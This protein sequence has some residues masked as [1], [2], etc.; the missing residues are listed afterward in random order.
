MTK[1]SGRVR[2]A[3]FVLAATV[4]P[5]AWV[6][7]AIPVRGVG[8]A[9]VILGLVPAYLAVRW[10]LDRRTAVVVLASSAVVLMAVSLVTWWGNGLT[11]ARWAIPLAAAQLWHGVD[12]YAVLHYALNP[13]TGGVAANYLWELP[14]TAVLWWPFPDYAW[15]MMAAWAGL[16]WVLRDRPAGLWAA[17]PVVGLLAANGN[18]DFLPLFLLALGLTTTAWW[19]EYLA[20]GMKQF[21]TVLAI[22]RRLARREWKKAV[23][24]VGF[25]AAICV[26]F[27][28]WNAGAFVCA[29]VLFEIPQGCPVTPNLPHT[30]AA[31]LGLLDANYALWPAFV[32]AM[33]PEQILGRLRRWLAP[34]H[35]VGGYARYIVVGGTSLLVNL[36][37]FQVGLDLHLPIL[38]AGAIGQVA[39]GAYAFALNYRFTFSDRV[40]R[41]WHVHLAMFAAIAACV[42]VINLTLLWMFLPY[43]QALLSQ[44]GATVIGSGIGYL[45]NR[46]FNFR[47]V[48]RVT[49]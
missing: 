46:R 40:G 21:A 1:P 14:L 48:P 36:G 12:P 24:L 42:I 9:A 20:A 15:P 45:A 31:G 47:P 26:P 34:G 7:L 27:L 25:T 49:T 6:G 41:P 4:P 43:F 17:S 39:A 10:C 29:A 30:Y 37:L 19:G 22:G 5:L 44:A 16:V 2:W 28:L 33:W 8:F 23:T 35:V 13:H 3:W 32:L 38:G 11:D 18:S